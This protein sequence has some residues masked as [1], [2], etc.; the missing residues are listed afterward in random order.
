[1]DSTM[2][3]TFEMDSCIGGYHVYKE[4]WTSNGEES[5]FLLTICHTV[6]HNRIFC[7]TICHAHNC[8]KLARDIFTR[9]LN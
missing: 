2:E 7:L 1:M 3:E 6:T 9:E 8:K 4:V 5:I